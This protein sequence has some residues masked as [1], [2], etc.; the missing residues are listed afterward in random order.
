MAI[1]RKFLSITLLWVFIF[2]ICWVQFLDDRIS[3]WKP[4]ERKK[5]VPRKSQRKTQQAAKVAQHVVHSFSYGLHRHSCL[6]LLQNYWKRGVSWRLFHLVD[7]LV[8]GVRGVHIF[9]IGIK[10]E[11]FYGLYQRLGQAILI[12]DLVGI[13]ILPF[14]DIIPNK[15]RVFRL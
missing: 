4:C 9:V 8:E 2:I 14:L 13:G 5:Q 7:K 11:E 6:T 3:E 12:K 1:L 15:L 10:L